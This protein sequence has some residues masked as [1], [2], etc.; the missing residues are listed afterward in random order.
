MTAANSFTGRINTDNDFVTVESVTVGVTGSNFTGFTAG[1][2]YTM[3]VQDHCTLKVSD[4]EFFI[5]VEHPYLQYKAGT[6][7]MYIK[8]DSLGC[9]LTI[10]EEADNA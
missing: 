10:L 6:D 1:K 8:T 7:D 9:T 4:A 2:V 5:S 3:Q